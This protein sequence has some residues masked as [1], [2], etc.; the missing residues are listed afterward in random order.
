MGYW[1]K[2][3]NAEPTRLLSVLF[4]R[5]H[6]EVATGV[7]STSDLVSFRRVMADIGMLGHWVV[8]ATA[9]DWRELAE[10]FCSTLAR[11]EE[12]DAMHNST[13]L[14]WYHRL[15]LQHSPH[16]HPYLAD[17][18]NLDGSRLQCACRVGALRL[19]TKVA[20]ERGLPQQAR[21][22]ICPS[23]EE[24]SLEHFL[25]D[26]PTLEACR[27]RLHRTLELSLP[28]FGEDGLSIL[29]TFDTRIGRLGLLLGRRMAWNCPAGSM[30][31]R[32]QRGR[33]EW[34][35][36]K[37]V[38][39]CL[40]ACWRR[41]VFYMQADEDACWSGAKLHWKWR[42]CTWTPSTGQASAL[43]ATHSLRN[44][45]DRWVAPEG[46]R[47]W[48]RKWGTRDSPTFMSSTAAGGP[49]FFFCVERLCTEHRIV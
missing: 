19:M 48:T 35:T 1:S 15:H 39:N 46:R 36:N 42:R 23:A 32:E 38:K 21:C 34:L 45:W 41:R 8:R 13:S 2:L 7:V 14:S 33:A 16:P 26:C 40:V 49:A 3:V 29:R 37:A 43:R 22:R 30:E 6:Q 20:R 28:A 12:S 31:S 10:S 47:R 17:R 18:S 27:V 4:R 25:L 44:H 11:A 5:R 24:E 9:P